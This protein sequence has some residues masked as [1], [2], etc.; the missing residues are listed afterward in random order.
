MKKGLVLDPRDN[1]GVVIETV[2][3]GDEVKFGDD[4]L[5]NSLSNIK[6]PHKMALVDIAE[7][8]MIIKYGEVIGYA[9]TQVKQGQFVHGHNLDSEKLMK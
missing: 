6:M 4:I 7:G 9:T 1:V 3:V 8:A 5:I 2:S